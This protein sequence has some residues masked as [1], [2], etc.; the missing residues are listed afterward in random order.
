MPRFEPGWGVLKRKRPRG[1][2][3][4]RGHVSKGNAL[5]LTKLGGALEWLFDA[6][7]HPARLLVLMAAAIAA[8]GFIEGSGPLPPY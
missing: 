1:G 7:E 6:D 8:V 5:I 4:A 3:G 2:N